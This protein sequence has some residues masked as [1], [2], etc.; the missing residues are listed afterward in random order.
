MFVCGIEFVHL[1]TKK[2]EQKAF[3]LLPLLPFLTSLGV[4]FP[5]ILS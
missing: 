4:E 1:I 5:K 3:Q 2:S